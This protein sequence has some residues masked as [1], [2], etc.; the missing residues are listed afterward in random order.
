MAPSLTS[1]TWLW[2]DG[3]LAGIEST[4]R[5]GV[6]KPKKALGGM[7]PLGGTQL[8]DEDVKALASYVWAIGHERSP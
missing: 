3:G 6:T 4:I 5:T 8:S 2:S 1:G 7:P